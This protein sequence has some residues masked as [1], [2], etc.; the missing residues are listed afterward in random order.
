MH[1][2]VKVILRMAC[3]VRYILLRHLALP[4]KII[5]DHLFNNLL[6]Q[7]FLLK[8]LVRGGYNCH[9]FSRLGSKA[10]YCMFATFFAKLLMGANILWEDRMV[11]L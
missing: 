7:G 8:F 6:D 2:F 5:R 1:K 11:V 9:K 3:T 10:F 4:R